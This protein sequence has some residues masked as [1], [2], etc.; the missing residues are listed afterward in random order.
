MG[1]FLQMLDEHL[2]VKAESSQPTS[3]TRRLVYGLKGIQDLLG[4]SHKAA[5]FYKDHIIC[6]AV[7]QCGRKIVTD[8]D[9][10]LKLFDQRRNRHA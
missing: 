9:L 4:C 10:A 8:A 1:E 6:E 2:A 5:Q 3:E 7:S